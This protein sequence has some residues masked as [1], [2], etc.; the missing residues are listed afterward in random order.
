MA[1]FIGSQS[2]IV[3]LTEFFERSSLQRS[4][5]NYVP[6]LSSSSFPFYYEGPDISNNIKNPTINFGFGTNLTS[7]K[8]V[9]QQGI[10]NSILAQY[11]APKLTTAQWSSYTGVVNENDGGALST[12]LNNAL[13]QNVSGWAP[14]A[15][16]LVQFYYDSIVPQGLSVSLSSQGFSG[17]SGSLPSTILY[18]LEDLQYNTGGKFVGPNLINA[19]NQGYVSGDYS[20]AAYEIAFDTAKPNSPPY[21]QRCLADG[22]IDAR[23]PG[24]AGWFI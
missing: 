13:P 6:V 23:L 7:I 1:T 18:P 20:A 10:N 12:N 9:S 11:D 8:S 4:L 17:V 21:T 19:L 14:L 16:A 5:V 22:L 15:S 2:G 24:V 3:S